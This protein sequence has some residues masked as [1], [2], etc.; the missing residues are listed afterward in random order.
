MSR[1]MRRGERQIYVRGIRRPQVDVAKLAR[2]MIDLTV[3]Q[4]EA[5]AKAEH[6]LRTQNSRPKAKGNT[7]RR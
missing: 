5:E 2:A 3:A 6:E 7:K 1:T 4:A